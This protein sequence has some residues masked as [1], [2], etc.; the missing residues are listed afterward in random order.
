[1]RGVLYFMSDIFDYYGLYDIRRM[2]LIDVERAYDMCVTPEDFEYL[3]DFL[4]SIQERDGPELREIK[5]FPGYFATDY[6][7]IATF[8][9]SNI[10][11]LSPWHNKHGHEYVQLYDEDKVGHKKTVHRLIAEAYVDNPEGYP[12]VRHLDDDPDNNEPY[13]LAWGTSQDNYDDMVRNGHDFKKPVY[14]YE[15]DIIYKSGAEAAYQLG[16][17]RPE[18]SQVCSGAKSSAH[19]YHLCY[20]KD[21]DDRL[22]SI[23]EWITEK[24]AKKPLHARNLDT[25]EEL[26][27]E[28][29]IEAADYLGI[30]ACGIS[31]VITG[32]AKHTHRWTFWED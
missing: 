3:N 22:D 10:K 15:T 31:S 24:S 19:G 13:N 7:K 4:N 1:M 6:G 9:G 18:V 17:T 12:L 14:C 21:L 26:Y 23:D 25:G 27:F 8:K 30:P 16:L 5:G 28:S 11:E 29:R 20:E 2:A 32:H